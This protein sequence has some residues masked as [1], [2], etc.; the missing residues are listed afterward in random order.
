[1]QHNWKQHT[2]NCLPENSLHLSPYHSSWRSSHSLLY[3]GPSDPTYSW[4]MKKLPISTPLTSKSHKYA[5]IAGANCRNMPH[6]AL[7]P[8]IHQYICI[9]IP[10]NS[11]IDASNTPSMHPPTNANSSN[12]TALSPTMNSNKSSSPHSILMSWSSEKPY[13]V[14]NP[15]IGRQ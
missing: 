11:H 13:T 7:T 10:R 5:L 6:K 9:N 12:W 15:S 4:S 1:M 3:I 2:W 14:T 8:K